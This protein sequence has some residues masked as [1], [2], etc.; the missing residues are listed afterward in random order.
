MIDLYET[1]CVVAV[2]HC[3]KCDCLLKEIG[4]EDVKYTSIESFTEHIRKLY[5]NKCP[6]CGEPL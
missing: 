6:N 1:S 3:S 5:D 4:C 2:L